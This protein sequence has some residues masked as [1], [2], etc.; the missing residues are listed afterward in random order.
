M[1]DFAGDIQQIELTIEEAQEQIDMKDC[2]GRLAV[3]PDFEKLITK[4]FFEDEAARA[5]GAKAEISM[6]MDKNG[7]TM[8]DNII[9]SIGGLRQYF[10]KI[11]QQGNSAQAAI[12]EHQET[13]AELLREEIGGGEVQ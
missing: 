5:V 2:L 11:Q 13:H 6:I 4:G 1:S 9:T 3:N 8:I 12:E 7:M 10:I